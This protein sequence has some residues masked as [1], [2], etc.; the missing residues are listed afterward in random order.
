MN[1]TKFLTSSLVVLASLAASSAFA[2]SYDREHPLVSNTPSTGTRAQVKAE[3]LAA[4]KDG[5][6]AAVNDDNYPLIKA[7]GTP[8]TRAEVRA[9]LAN[10]IKEGSIPKYHD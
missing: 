9:E 8:K 3:L 4:Q 10:A 6:M 1:T 5:T 2:D 7:V